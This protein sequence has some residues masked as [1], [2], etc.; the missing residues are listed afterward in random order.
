MHIVDARMETGHEITN[1]HGFAKVIWPL[2]FAI[3]REHFYSSSYQ[4]SLIEDPTHC[5]YDRKKPG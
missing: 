5:S 1:L 3:S 2:F 4:V